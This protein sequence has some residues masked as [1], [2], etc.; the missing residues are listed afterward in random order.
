MADKIDRDD[1]D[2]GAVWE[3]EREREQ[4][5]AEA[6]GQ[7]KKRDFDGLLLPSEPHLPGLPAL[8]PR[9]ACRALSLGA[10]RA[11]LAG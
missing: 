5:R 9:R 7:K 11:G 4:N 8:A 3:I 1:E 6:G 2:A 10:P